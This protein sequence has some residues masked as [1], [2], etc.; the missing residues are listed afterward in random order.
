[1]RAADARG[2]ERDGQLAVDGFDPDDYLNAGYGGDLYATFRWVELHGELY[3][4]LWEHPT[5]PDLWATSGY[6][7]AK[8][9]F[10]P[11]WYVAARGGFFE[12]GRVEDSVGVEH[13]WDYPVRRL[14]WGVGHQPMPR[15]VVKV[16]T[17]H[18]RFQGNGAL[19]TDHYI[20]QLSAGF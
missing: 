9:K 3:R 11:G 10:T 4:T 13:A 17:K 6:L 16:V 19:D 15:V 20:V 14:E 1:M 7:D 2:G 5:L 18:N 8:Y 12:P